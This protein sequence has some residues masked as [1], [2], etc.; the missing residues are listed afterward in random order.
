MRDRFC[1]K[2]QKVIM[3]VSSL[4]VFP[5]VLGIAAVQLNVQIKR[6]ALNGMK[7]F[8]FNILFLDDELWSFFYSTHWTSVLRFQT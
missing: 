8:P 4:P 2:E 3:Y 5:L 1:A 6:R 7:L